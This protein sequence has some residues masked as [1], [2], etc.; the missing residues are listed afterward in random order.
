ML[1]DPQVFSNEMQLFSLVI[2]IF[3]KFQRASFAL[4]PCLLY[5]QRSLKTGGV[6]LS[7]ADQEVRAPR[8]LLDQVLCYLLGSLAQL[9]QHSRNRVWQGLHRL[10]DT[11]RLAFGNGEV[12]E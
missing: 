8:Q 11:L 1:V 3:L 12:D 4:S 6:V 7:A 9:I 5:L 10:H 2:D